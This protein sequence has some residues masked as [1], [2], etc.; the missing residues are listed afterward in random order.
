MRKFIVAALIFICILPCTA[1]LS[2]AHTREDVR[3]MY[4][5]LV[6]GREGSPYAEQPA[7]SYPYAHG[8]LTDAALEDAAAY[9]NFIRRLAY[10]ENDVALN[11]LYV[12]RAQH[13]AVLLAANDAL[14]HDSPNPGD[15]PADFYE[16]A[17]T[18]TMSSNI[19]AIN[20]IDE[21]MLL[22]ALEYFVRDDG[23]T[24]LSVLGHRRWLLDPCLGMT[25]FGLADSATGK[26][27]AVMYVHD[28][29]YDP[30]VWNNVKWPSEG[31]FPVELTSAH[32]P[33]SVSL[34]M[35]VY[36]ADL[37]EVSVSMY[38]QTAGH[39]SL[40]YFGVDA[41]NYG[42]G[43]CIIFMPDLAEMGITDYQQNQ[44]WHVRIDGLRTADGESA[45]IEYRV[46]M[47]SLYPV[48]AAA[49]EVDPRAL[50]MQTGDICL[51][52]AQV[53]PDWADDMSVTWTSSDETVAVV[54]ENGYVTA[55][56]PGNCEITAASVNGRMDVC[57]VHVR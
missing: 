36:S 29:S 23:E 10:L 48:D 2:E 33:W 18:G 25:G 24:N 5:G 45:S 28:L 27:Y 15:M 16:T 32:I 26:S 40:S 8:S 49:V 19:A 37:S 41:G 7:I 31:A 44:V 57:S 56:G 4:S 51:L 13:A 54:D 30:G 34:D 46:D 39:A 42:S 22:T 35:Q 52:T 9:M 47:I 17:H 50:D 43:P 38:E 14:E 6:N 3:D 21:N 11:P 55:V 1:A 20:W 53:V 12:L